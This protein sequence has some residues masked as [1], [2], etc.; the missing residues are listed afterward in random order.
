MVWWSMEKFI[1]PISSANDVLM[2][3]LASTHTRHRYNMIGYCHVARELQVI[4]ISIRRGHDLRS[5]K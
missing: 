5:A 4:C 2:L 1:C 3:S